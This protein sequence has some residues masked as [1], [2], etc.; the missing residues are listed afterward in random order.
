MRLLHLMRKEVLELRSDPRLFG[1]VL[2]APIV[3]LTLLGYAATTDVADV[4]ADPT[5]VQRL[6]TR[7]SRSSSTTAAPSPLPARQTYRTSDI[8][9]R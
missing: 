5:P 6:R 4:S 2:V 1:I 9:T 8:D 7:K 3:Q